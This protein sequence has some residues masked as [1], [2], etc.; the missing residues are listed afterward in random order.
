VEFEN[1]STGDLKAAWE[2]AKRTLRAA[3]GDG[4]K[5]AKW[6]L[7]RIERAENSKTVFTFRV[8]NEMSSRGQTTGT[9][10][11]INLAQVQ[12]VDN[13]ST[14]TSALMLH[15]FGHAFYNASPKIYNADTSDLT[16]LNFENAYRNYLGFPVRTSH[17]PPP[18]GFW[19]P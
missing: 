4:D 8:N 6:A 9:L 11:Q 16:A 2:H 7:G 18:N 13:N 10:M 3:A 12:R 15:E 14:N 1:D 5:D 17:G 19:H